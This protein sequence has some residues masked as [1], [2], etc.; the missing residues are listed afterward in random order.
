MDCP[1]NSLG[2]LWVEG[3]PND[4]LKS[5]WKYYLDEAEQGP[6]V[7]KQLTEIRREYSAIK[8][9]EIKCIDPCCGSGHILAYMFDVLIQI[10]GAYG[11][12]ARD[13][14]ASIVK[15]NIYGLDIDE[16]AAQ[17]AQFSVM[18]KARQYDR[19]FFS[20][21]VQPNVYAIQDSN[22]I[23]SA[24]LHDMGIGLSSDDYSK[25]V[26]QIMQLI[27]EFHDAK[28]YGSI[29]NVNE[30][31]WD[32]LRRF[33]VPRWMSEGGQIS[34]EIHGEIDAAP[35][36]QQ[37]INIGQALSQKY[38]AVVTNPPYLSARGSM[39][40]S[41]TKYLTKNY[42]LSK[43]DLF[44]VFMDVCKKLLLP[45]GLYSM[46]NQQS[47]MFLA[48]FAKFRAQIYES[49]TIENL[50]HIGTGAFEGIAGEVVQSVAFC[51]RNVRMQDYRA[52]YVDLT[53]GKWKNYIFGLKDI[54]HKYQISTREISDIPNGILCYHLGGAAIRQYYAG[55][56]LDSFADP[57]VGMAT[58]D[59]DLFV[60]LWQEVD[61]TKIG[62]G[63]VDGKSTEQSE[64]NG[65]PI[66][67]VGN[68]EGGMEIEPIWLT[69]TIMDKILQT[70]NTIIHVFRYMAYGYP[71][72]PFV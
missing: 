43:N 7:Q 40:S 54:A 42:P 29:I 12:S 64:K 25:A 16:R 61:F 52:S 24:P 11:I 51:I 59:N 6:D 2:R 55:K 23:T 41:L 63:F 10:Y 18:M 1:V 71:L 21:D 45:N 22:G 39:S 26:K 57:R 53:T 37:L 8:P 69:G 68:A 72:N 20:R 58:G 48:G 33:A 56:R 34:F 62:F 3:H 14:A 5:Q 32:L 46:V 28:E 31:D 44:T 15:N 35:R 19:R 4:E 66:T 30:A 38:H 60:R 9:E 17:L 65:T 13:A 50:I 67:R 49:V 47:W 70:L 27:D 36:L